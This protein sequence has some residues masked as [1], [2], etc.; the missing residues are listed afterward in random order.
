MPMN[1]SLF[2][3]CFKCGLEKHL[4]QFYK[5]KKMKD[6]HFNKCKECSKEDS[7]EHRKNNR[8]YYLNYD[9]NRP[10]RKNVQKVSSVKKNEYN[11]TWEKKNPTKRKAHSVFWY[12]IRLGKIERKTNC[13]RCGQ[14]DRI[15]GHHHDYDKPLEVEWLC[16]QCHAKEH[17]KITV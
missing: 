7:K 11:K 5:H 15:H 4:S 1:L 12:A 10:P 3:K 17:R 6:G 13:E 14:T 9:R 8:G 16:I 2:K